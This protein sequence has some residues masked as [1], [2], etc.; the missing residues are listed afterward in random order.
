[1]NIVYAMTRNV[2]PWILPSLRSLAEHNPDAKVFIL[3][4]DD[5]LPFDLPIKATIINVSGQTFFHPGSV[6]FRNQFSY[7][8]LLKVCYPEILPK[9]QKVI[10]L[11]I[12]T[13][14]CDSLED[15]WKFNVTGKWFAAAQERRGKYHPFGPDYYNMDVALIN[16]QQMRKDKIQP[17]LMHYLA[18][19][20]QPWADQ[21]AWNKFAIEQGKAVELPVRWN[22]NV[23]TGFT[24]NPGIV[25]FCSIGD[26]WTNKGMSRRE[27]LEKYMK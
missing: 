24:D 20:P 18:T 2:Y 10:H 21:D 9:C 1:M 16:L 15:L 7:I 12:D 25:H 26:W 8:N 6:N 13:I 27:Y 5:A 17:D 3:A 22:E 4:E 11:D 19:V 23:M 14:V